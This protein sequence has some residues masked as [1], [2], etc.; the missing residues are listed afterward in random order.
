LEVEDSGPGFGED[1]PIFDAF[2]TTKD[3]GTGLGLS[4]V[5]R[6]VSEHG[7]T[8]GCVSKPGCTRF[9]ITLPELSTSVV[10]A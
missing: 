9:S 4:I 3:H 6:I 8:I 1:V 5:H 7:G 10:Y 2:F